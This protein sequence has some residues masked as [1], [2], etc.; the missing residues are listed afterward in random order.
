MIW[1]RHEIRNHVWDDHNDS[2]LLE[3]VKFFLIYQ[4]YKLIQ[5]FFAAFVF[6]KIIL[7]SGS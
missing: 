4:N 2:L 7:R 1:N 3:K 6:G 5:K